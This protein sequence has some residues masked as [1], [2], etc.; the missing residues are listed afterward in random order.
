[1]WNLL[2]RILRRKKKLMV[3]LGAGASVELGMPSV[4]DI[5]RLFHEWAGPDFTLATPEPHPI[6]WTLLKPQAACLVN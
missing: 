4:S 2:A 5:D 6:S 3:V 1:M